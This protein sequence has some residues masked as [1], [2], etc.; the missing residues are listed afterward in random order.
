VG[1][2][3]EHQRP[4][5]SNIEAHNPASDLP[6]SLVSDGQNMRIAEVV[7]PSCCGEPSRPGFCGAIMQQVGM[8]RAPKTI[9]SRAKDR[10][11][12]GPTGI[13][14]RSDDLRG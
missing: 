1:S 11:G 2:N 4:R 8:K 3:Q 9:G 7:T 14:C 5:H 12:G 6:V 10:A 13:N